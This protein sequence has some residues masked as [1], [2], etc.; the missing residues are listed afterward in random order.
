MVIN[1][2]AWLDLE[3][4]INTFKDTQ[5]VISIQWQA[6]LSIVNPLYT[7]HDNLNCHT[8][9]HNLSVSCLQYLKK[10]LVTFWADITSR[11]RHTVVESMR[12]RCPVATND[13]GGHIEYWGSRHGRTVPVFG[14]SMH[15]GCESKHVKIRSFSVKS[16]ETE[17]EFSQTFFCGSETAIKRPFCWFY[18]NSS[19]LFYYMFW[20]AYRMPCVSVLGQNDTQW[21]DS[22]LIQ[23][24]NSQKSNIK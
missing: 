13:H 19:I 1:P 5:N 22:F 2:N 6:L 15:H 4:V 21:Q 12:R 11:K 24:Q 3:N 10:A 8:N 9:G 16:Y 7:I 17:T 20:H 18:F 23:N 14:Y